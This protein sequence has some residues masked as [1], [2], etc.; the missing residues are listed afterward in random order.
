[1]TTKDGISCYHCLF[2]V[3]QRI[4]LEAILCWDPREIVVF[5]SSLHISH[6][7]FSPWPNANISLID[8]FVICIPSIILQEQKHMVEGITVARLC[9]AYMWYLINSSYTLWKRG[10]EVVSCQLWTS[11]P[12][13]WICLRVNSWKNR[14]VHRLFPYLSTFSG[15]LNSQ[16]SVVFPN[17]KLWG[18]GL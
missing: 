16:C 3:F 4:F 8:N 18:P 6:S 13:S 17:A 10:R 11:I 5:P 15:C 12:A 14:G 9:L 7:Y 1:M 2:L